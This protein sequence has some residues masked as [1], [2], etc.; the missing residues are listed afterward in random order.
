MENISS[1]TGCLNG[2]G[3]QDSMIIIHFNIF[4]GIY[5]SGYK[6]WVPYFLPLLSVGAGLKC[7]LIPQVN[8]SQAG[9]TNGKG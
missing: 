8:F 7:C 4:D 9:P 1:S 3:I 5:M 6:S 2:H